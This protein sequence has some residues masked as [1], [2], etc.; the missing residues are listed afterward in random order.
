MIRH[1]SLSLLWPPFSQLPP[2]LCS[3]SL[4]LPS[5]QDP[6]PLQTQICHIGDPVSKGAW[7]PEEDEQGALLLN[8]NPAQ[9][10]HAVWGD[11][12]NPNYHTHLQLFIL[13]RCSHLKPGYEGEIYRPLADTTVY[14]TQ[15]FPASASATATFHQLLHALGF[16]G[17]LFQTWREGFKSLE[18]KKKDWGWDQVNHSTAEVLLWGWVRNKGEL[19]R[20]LMTQVSFCSPDPTLEGPCRFKPLIGGSRRFLANLTSQLLPGDETRHPSRMPHV[21]EAELT[22]CCCLHQCLERAV[23]KVLAEG[24]SWA[25][26]LPEK[27]IQMSI[28]SGLAAA[29]WQKSLETNEVT[30]AITYKPVSLSIQNLLFQLSLGLVG[31]PG[32]SLGKEGCYIHSPLITTS[33]VFTAHMWKSPGCQ[34]SSVGMLTLTLQKKPLEILVISDHNSFMTHQGL[35]VGFCPMLF[36]LWMHWEPWPIRKKLLF[37]WDLL[38]FYHSPELQCTTG[39]PVEGSEGV[40]LPGA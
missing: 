22:G 16:S 33:L 28:R 26:C 40:M 39:G 29:H 11:P 23:Y 32:D 37:R 24:S 4:T 10:C 27:A 31:P 36:F 8:P 2:N 35:S 13:V 6:Q 14:C 18:K 12:D 25:P 38:P 3:S 19:L 34:G 1:S 7:N 5:P 21:K 30:N 20:A 15:H 9:Y 17:W